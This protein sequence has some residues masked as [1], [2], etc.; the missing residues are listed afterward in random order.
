MS[1]ITT[2]LTQLMM[3]F[4]SK[5]FLARAEA[6]LRYDY[7]AQ[8][9]KHPT[10][11]GK[12][13]YFNRFSPLAVAT[14]P[15]T[16]AAMP[17]AVDMTSNIVSAVIAEYGTYTKVGSLFELTSID[18]NLKEHVETMGQN[19]AETL[20]TLIAAELSANGTVVLAGAKSALTAVAATDILSGAE[21][22]KQLRTLRRAKAKPFDDGMFRAIVPVS[23]SYDLRG[24]TE[25]VNTQLYVNRDS[26]LKGIIGQFHGFNF[27]ET[28]NESTEASTVTVYHSFFFGAN[29]YGTLNLEGQ[30]D[31]R[32]YVKNPGDNDTSNPLNT[33]STVGWKAFF[34]AKIL[35]S[36]WVNVLKSGA[37]A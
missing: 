21:V 12:T 28:N 14:T 23:A 24:N 31:S 34:V 10:N 1:S 4:Y 6:D 8:K 2:G 27:V 22:R 35:N 13:V 18:E 29:A 26:I 20:D 25:W 17:G 19:A 30:P 9:R 36:S 33:W 7:G 3:I 15:L 37:T 32:I 5:V 16:E 11:S